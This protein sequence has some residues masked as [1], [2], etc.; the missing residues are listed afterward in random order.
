MEL[1]LIFGELI[2]EIELANK[3]YKFRKNLQL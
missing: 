2:W 3:T 1:D